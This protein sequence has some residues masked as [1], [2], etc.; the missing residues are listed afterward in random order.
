[1]T[2]R[3]RDFSELSSEYTST[4]LIEQ[5]TLN[6]REVLAAAKSINALRVLRQVNTC[7]QGSVVQ[8]ATNA[9]GVSALPLSVTETDAIVGLLIERHEAFLSALNIELEE[10][11]L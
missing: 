11:H 6:E 7:A 4:D 10:D 5:I 2:E 3:D 8:L 1:M 9:A